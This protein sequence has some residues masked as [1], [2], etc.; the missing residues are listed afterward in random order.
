M[1]FLSTLKCTGSEDAIGVY[2]YG[3]LVYTK[4]IMHTITMQKR[5]ELNVY[6][7]TAV[8]AAK[9][10]YAD[11]ENRSLYSDRISNAA[12]FIATISSRI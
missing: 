3:C 12:S 11:N 10:F 7:C 6:N 1:H 2:H 9:W 4:V 8:P 5:F